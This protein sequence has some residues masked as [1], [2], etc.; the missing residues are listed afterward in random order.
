[1]MRKL[2]LNVKQ[3]AERPANQTISVRSDR[4]AERRIHHARDW[5]V[6]ENSVEI[7][8]SPEEVFDYCTDLTREPEWNAKAKRV[9]RLTA[10]P[11]G[12][13]TQYEAEFLA[14]D[15]MTIE[16]VRFE[17]PTAWDAAGRSPRLDAKTEGRISPTDDGARL[18]MRMELKPKG[19]LR[20]LLPVMARYMHRQEERNLATIKSALEG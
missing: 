17:R 8:R 15:P 19:T 11:I 18:V 10:G 7:A 16:L 14:G 4:R 5:A 2:L 1:M 3:R 20:L 13:G 9:E 12:L 6:L